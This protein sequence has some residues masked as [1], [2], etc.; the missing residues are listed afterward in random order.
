MALSSVAQTTEE[1]VMN[2]MI[3]I[4]VLK[5]GRWKVR[6]VK[7]NK[8]QGLVEYI[9][10]VALIG[11]LSIAALNSLGDET[12]SGFIKSTKNLNKEFKNL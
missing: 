7:S 10:I 12:R 9:L 1:A 2:K 6:V 4:R 8:G 11:I 3:I 5:S